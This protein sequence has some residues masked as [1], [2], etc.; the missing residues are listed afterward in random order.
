[1]S[2]KD[3][4]YRVK[5]FIKDKDKKPPLVMVSEFIN[6]WI[7]KGNIPMHYF[8]RFLYRKRYTNP[9]DY[10]D[11]KQYRAI[12]FSKRNNED[13]YV[14]LLSNKF[15]FSLLCEKHRLPTPT[16]LS[17]NMRG[18]FFYADTLSRISK[19]DEL[20]QF[21]E[22]VFNTTSQK[23]LFIKSF[24][25]YGGTEVFLVHREKLYEQLKNFGDILLTSAFIHQESIEQ[26]SDL[27]KIYPNSVNTIR[28]ETYIDKSGKAN[29]LGTFIRF[30]A[31]GRV[32]DNVS[33]GGFYVPVHPETGTLMATGIQS[34]IFGGNEFKKHP[35]TNFQFEGFRIPFFDEAKN[36]CMKLTEYIPNRLAGWDI[37]ITP[38]G[39]VVIEGNHTPGITV[40]EIG[41]GG[42]VKHPLFTEMISK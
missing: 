27:N 40:G 18:N 3:N 38:S 25:G 37:A 39:P 13:E 21:F 15:L 41:Y 28:I 35:D 11:M 4:I 23:R 29:I 30:G 16:V 20:I 1:M 31:N 7:S 32:V 19:I 9:S 42:Y 5:V 34:M 6:L 24:C 12:I 10:M 14:H 22:T 26:H 8:G 36:L 2:L 17:Y 33:S